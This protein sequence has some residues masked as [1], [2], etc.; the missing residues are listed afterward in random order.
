MGSEWVFSWHFAT[1]GSFW[2]EAYNL[3]YLKYLKY[4]GSFW[5]FQP[6]IKAKTTSWKMPNTFLSVPN[7]N[8]CSNCTGNK[9]LPQTK[10]TSSVNG[11]TGRASTCIFTH[12]NFLGNTSLT[13]RA[14]PVGS[15][16]QAITHTRFT[17]SW[18]WAAKSPHLHQRT[19]QVSLE[20]FH[21]G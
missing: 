13:K 3:K 19:V 21:F 14:S 15:T 11:I 9:K 16:S 7:L 6:N 5:L 10:Q 4:S 18:T 12:T 8:F 1:S 17:E 20:I 2:R